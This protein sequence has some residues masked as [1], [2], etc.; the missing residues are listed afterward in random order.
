MSFSRSAASRLSL[1]ASLTASSRT[2]ARPTRWSITRL[3]TLPLRKPGTEICAAM[4]LYAASSEGLSSSNG[5]S[6]VSFTRVGD[7]VSTALFTWIGAPGSVRAGS[8]AAV[9]GGWWSECSAGSC[10]SG[11]PCG[12]GPWLVGAGRLELPI[13][14]PQ[15]RRASHYATPRVAPRSY[16]TA[17]NRP[18]ARIRSRDLPAALSDR[19]TPAAVESWSSRFAVRGCSSMAEPQPSKLAMPVR[20]RSPAPLDAL[21]SRRRSRP[22]VRASSHRG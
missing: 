4:R 9:R 11:S 5:T 21:T 12:P 15:S 13:S 6:T 14:C 7:R 18:T 19:G 20:S 17:S 8:R 2:A 1:M 22:L 10:G 16:G 3:G